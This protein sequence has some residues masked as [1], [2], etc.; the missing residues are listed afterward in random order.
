[1]RLAYMTTSCSCHAITL[2]GKRRE[3]LEAEQSAQ[4]A[5]TC[6]AGAGG[7]AAGGGRPLLREVPGGYGS[8]RIRLPMQQQAWSPAA[9]RCCSGGDG[10]RPNWAARGGEHHLRRSKCDQWVVTNA[11]AWRASP[12]LRLQ[13]RGAATRAAGGCC[14]P[15]T[16]REV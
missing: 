13:R 15:R 7:A 3:R 10:R 4:G 1:M 8:Q 2:L 12:A 9:C 16:G 14:S 5:R 11:R 6:S